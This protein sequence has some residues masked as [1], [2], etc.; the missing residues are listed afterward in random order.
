MLRADV[1]EHVLTFVIRLDARRRLKRQSAP[2]V[3][4]E[5]RDTLWPSLRI[6]TSCGELDFNGALRHYSP[7][8]SPLLNRSRISCGSSANASAMVSSSI[9][10]RASGFWAS[11]WRSCSERLKR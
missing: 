6:K 1:D 3:I 5:D 10:Y 8:L 11:A 2:S 7:V 4:S 9:E